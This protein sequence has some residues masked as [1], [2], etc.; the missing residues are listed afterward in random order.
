[1]DLPRPTGGQWTLTL[2]VGGNRPAG[3]PPATLSIVVDDRP[4]QTIQFDS[5]PAG[6]EFDVGYRNLAMAGS[7]R[8]GSRTDP[9]RV[10]LAVNTWRP[11]DFGMGDIRELGVAITEVR[12]D[13]AN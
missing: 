12:V 4:A 3:V 7:S 8:P 9:I 10:K 13:E 6:A 2:R 5:L 11:A 1:M